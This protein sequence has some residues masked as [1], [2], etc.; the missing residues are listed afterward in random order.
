[1]PI[2][3]RFV[4]L[5]FICVAFDESFAAQI[6]TV[7]GIGPVKIGMAIEEAERALGAKLDPISEA[8][9]TE[10]WV[11]SRS[12]KIDPSIQYMI[13]DETIV[14]INV[15]PPGGE[16]FPLPRPAIETPEG[17]GVGSMEKKINRSYGKI[18]K[19]ELAPYYDKDSKD[20]V[21]WIHV[22]NPDKKMGMIFTVRYGRVL[23]FSVGMHGLHLIECTDEVVTKSFKTEILRQANTNPNHPAGFSPRMLSRATRSNASRWCGP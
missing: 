12:D 10:C 23:S 8:F 11:T 6:A 19:K 21:Y 7:E 18:V 22:D 4:V 2:K 16:T 17:I 13:E 15:Y 20:A 5:L 1:M 3:M 14:A 9:G